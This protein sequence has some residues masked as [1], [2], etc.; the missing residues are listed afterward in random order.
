MPRALLRDAVLRS[1][2]LVPADAARGAAQHSPASTASST[3][4]QGLA[5]VRRS[6]TMA[7]RHPA[8]LL[9]TLAPPLR[10]SQVIR[11][12]YPSLPPQV[13]DTVSRRMAGLA[14]S[15]PVLSS[16][17]S[18]MPAAR[19]SCAPC[20][21]DQGGHIDLGDTGLHQHS[22]RVAAVPAQQGRADAGCSASGTALDTCVPGLRPRD[23]ALQTCT[24]SMTQPCLKC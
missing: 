5:S 7:L 12:S 10:T 24:R 1:Q 8:Q 17:L 19:L 6:R 22:A 14:R 11:A 3:A 13:R 2:V 20:H 18:L 4:G 23:S 16:D 9:Y 21:T 15:A